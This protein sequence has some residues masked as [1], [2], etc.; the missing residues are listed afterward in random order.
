MSLEIYPHTLFQSP[1]LANVGL[2]PE[3]IKKIDQFYKRFI[4]GL[5]FTQG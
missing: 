2:L 4:L 3:K 1:I 5:F